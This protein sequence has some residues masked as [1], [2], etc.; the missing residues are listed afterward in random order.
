MPPGLDHVAA[1]GHDLGDDPD[2]R[3]I[4][5]DPPPVSWGLAL[6]ALGVTLSGADAVDLAKLPL[7]ADLVPVNAK[8]AH[9]SIVTLLEGGEE[10]FRK[11]GER[12]NF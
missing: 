5:F 6:L 1:L 9:A 12:Y 8:P 11:R 4:L 3:A 7:P 10:A 2:P